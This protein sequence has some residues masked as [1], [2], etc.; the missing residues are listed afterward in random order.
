MAHNLQKWYS[1]FL[2]KRNIDAPTGAHLYSYHF[3]KQEFDDL[4]VELGSF[5]KYHGAIRRTNLTLSELICILMYAAQWWHRKYSGGA[6]SWDDVFADV[7]P[8]YG[9]DFFYDVNERS[10]IIET[11][12]YSFSNYLPDAGKR[13]FACSVREGGIPLNALAEDSKS[14]LGNFLNTFSLSCI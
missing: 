11:A 8:N 10:A 7:V 13:F 1:S 6:W 4:T 3:T 9:D 5:R 2:Q 12:A 14:N